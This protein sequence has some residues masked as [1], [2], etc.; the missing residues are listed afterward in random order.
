MDDT[1]TTSALR[2]EIAAERRELADVLDGL[3]A[4]G[5]AT[6]SLCPGW[7]TR[8]VVAHMTMPYRYSAP[9]VLL[10]VLR[11]RG[12]FDR[13]ADRA[14]RHDAAAVPDAD[15]AATLRANAG[16]PWKPSVGGY[17]GALTHDVVHGLDFTVPL[18]VDRRPPPGR[19]AP[20]LDGLV[21]PKGLKHF[22]VDLAG[23][24]LRA[25]DLEWAHGS[26]APLTGPA[27]ALVLV[28]TG[29]VLPPGLVR[30]PAAARFTAA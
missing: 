25:D 22:G 2:A 5:W 3:D 20:V 28:L 27:H 23:A 8:E 13:F 11:A 7:R 4:A 21:T 26:G 1:Q 30:G 18:G 16:H 17:A 12:D 14:A 10:G 15:L 6:P 9:K 29:R 24:E 19:L